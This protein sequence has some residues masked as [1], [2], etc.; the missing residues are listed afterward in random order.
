MS[1]IATRSERREE[2]PNHFDLQWVEELEAETARLMAEIPENG[3]FILPGGTILSAEMQLA[4]T[5]A[6]R[7]ERR[8]WTLERLDPLPEG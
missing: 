5:V 2:N 6:R 4:R 8:L 7:A 1:L 3:F